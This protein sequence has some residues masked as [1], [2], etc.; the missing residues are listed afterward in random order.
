MTKIKPSESGAAGPS[1]GGLMPPE[2]DKSQRIPSSAD[3]KKLHH[4]MKTTDH[5]LSMDELAQKYGTD[6][7]NGLTS[8]KAEELLKAHGPNA[9]EPPKTVPEWVKI[10]KTQMSGFALL[11]WVGAVLSF[12]AFFFGYFT[13]ERPSY[14]YVYLG[15]VLVF[16]VVVTG[17]F[18]Y[19][20]ER[21]SAKILESFANMVPTFAQVYRDGKKTEVATEKI[22]L[23]D[24][25]EV[26]GGDRVP[27]DIR[28]IL[29]QGFKVDN[30]SLT[31]ESE[32]M[33]RSAECTSDDPL[34]SKN[35]AFY[36][37]FAVEGSTKGIVV[38]T[39]KNTAVGKIAHL[40]THLEQGKTPIAKE[41]ENFIGLV[42]IVAVCFG[43]VFF[44]IALFL[45][46]YWVDAVIFLIGIIVANVPE[47]ILATVT[48]CLS[49]AAKRMASRNCLVKNLEAV[50]TLGATSTICSD[51]TGTLTQNRMTVSHLWYDRNSE[52]C[53]ATSIA[54]TLTQ[55][56]ISQFTST[57][58]KDEAYFAL[59]RISILCNRAEFKPAQTHIPVLRRECTGDPSEQALLRFTELMIGDIPNIRKRNPKLLE[60]PFNST[61]KFQLS[62][63]ET[64][65][66]V[67]EY[68]IVV[69]GAP[70]RIV[71]M[72]TT[73]L[74]GEKEVP[75]DEEVREDFNRAYLE[76]GGKGER[77]LGFADL[78]LDKD[79][80]PRGFEFNAEEMNFPS[81]SLRF[82]GLVSLIDPPRASVPSAVA[83]ARSAGINVV[84]VT[85]DHPITAQAIARAVGILTDETETVE[86]IAIRKQCDISQVDPKEASAIVVHGS[87]LRE[88]N[89]QQLID[90]IR[91]HREIV[92]ARTSPQQKLAIVQ[93]FQQLG[94]IVAVTGDGVNDSPALKKA[95]IGI[96]M[97]IS[98]SD[99]SK[100]VAL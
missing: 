99:V 29:S 11:L 2:S 82:I 4:E 100:Q 66:G 95:D 3:L 67:E 33:S 6:L 93:A 13:T 46:T 94:H 89:E 52:V 17:L 61:N 91:N 27:A 42:T 23:G 20:Q 5:K 25:V 19:Y 10:A 47:G 74:V 63:H 71:D 15:S 85:G 18:Q 84:M 40:A 31:G 9:L 58:P 96:A 87:E 28:I 21:K 54:H 41:L 1:G 80:Y 70:E 44:I 38:N 50:E 36:S 30:S 77:V 16:V 39:G 12:F 48:V 51:K 75:F 8:A 37:T 86:D 35:M 69:K 92:F 7:E 98:G 68:L 79:K 88:M 26:H 14:D 24:I 57:G 60:I 53:S 64:D 73:I 72:C 78:R 83:K 45:H 76:L 81:T 49:L 62:I 97:G 90:V 32:P 22:V 55:L 43:F 34:E 56:S 65:D 59:M